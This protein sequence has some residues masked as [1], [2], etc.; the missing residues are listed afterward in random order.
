MAVNPTSRLKI[1]VGLISSPPCFFEGGLLFVLEHIHFH[2]WGE[3]GK[4]EV[5]F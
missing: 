1:N 5:C 4:W 2:L 3:I